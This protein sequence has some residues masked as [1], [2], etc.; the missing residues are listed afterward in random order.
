MKGRLALWTECTVVFLSLFF[1]YSSPGIQRKLSSKT[2][3]KEEVGKLQSEIALEKWKVL[4]LEVELGKI[5]LEERVYT[6][7]LS[8]SALLP[9]SKETLLQTY[10]KKI[11]TLEKNLTMQK[12][13]LAKSHRK[14]EQAEK[15]LRK[16]PQ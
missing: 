16:N 2:Y 15:Q 13:L 9:F 6:D 5:R 11:G 3:W 14:L 10:K 4:S 12:Q 1:I 8:D 7:K